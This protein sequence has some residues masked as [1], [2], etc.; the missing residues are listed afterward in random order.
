ME[1]LA[2]MEE[3]ES[4]GHRCCLYVG[5]IGSIPFDIWHHSDIRAVRGI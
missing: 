2:F 4:P 3:I 5:G 1:V